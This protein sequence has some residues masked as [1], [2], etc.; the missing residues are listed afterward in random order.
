VKDENGNLLA[1]SNNILNRCK[2]YFSQIFSVH[3]VSKVR[4]I[5]IYAADPFVPHPS[6][7]EV[8]IVLASLKRYK[9]PVSDQIPAELIK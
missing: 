6:R 3:S 1:D 5:E 2:N 7:F 4:Q 9:S 8:E